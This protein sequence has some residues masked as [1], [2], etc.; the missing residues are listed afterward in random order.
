MLIQGLS[1]LPHEIITE[2]FPS[3]SL[4]PFGEACLLVGMVVR[5]Q[6]SSD[7]TS[8]TKVKPEQTELTALVGF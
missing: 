1:G 3:D 4:Q 2:L 8:C 6:Y 5:F 7:I